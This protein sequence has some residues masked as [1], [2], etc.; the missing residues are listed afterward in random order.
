LQF[1][2]KVTDSYVTWSCK[3]NRLHWLLEPTYSSLVSSRLFR[4]L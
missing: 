2:V 4:F 3:F 1:L